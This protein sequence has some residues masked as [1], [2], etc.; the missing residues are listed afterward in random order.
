METFTV[1]ARSVSG[2][3]DP[4]ALENNYFATPVLIDVTLITIAHPDQAVVPVQPVEI[5]VPCQSIG[6]PDNTMNIF[7]NYVSLLK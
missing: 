1:A 4:D 7:H 3:F 2:H 5:F 6:R